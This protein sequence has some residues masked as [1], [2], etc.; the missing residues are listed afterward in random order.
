[1]KSLRLFD[2]RVGFSLGALSVLLGMMAPAAIPM[3]ASA[4]QIT[5]RSI[6]M[7]NTSVSGS[8]GTNVSYNL[9]FTP[10]QAGVNSD[11]VVLWFCSD[12][13]LAGASCAAPSGMSL[14]SASL[15]N[16]PGTEAIYNTSYTGAGANYLVFGTASLTGGSSYSITV[17]GVTNPSTAGTFY[18]RI[19]T[20]PSTD[21]TDVKKAGGDTG[22]T[23]TA[24]GSYVT[25]MTDNGSVALAATN[26]IGVSAS[27]LESLTF[28]TFGD[29]GNATVSSGQYTVGTN[30]SSGYLTGLAN[31][32]HGPNGDCTD[33][34][35]ANNGTSI[36]LGQQ[37]ATGVLA[38]S[39]ST[40]SYGYGWTGLSTNA[41]GGA[42]VYM[43]NN[44]P[45]DGLVLN[46]GSTCG[47]PS[48][49]SG[50]QGL[51][52]AFPSAGTAAYGVTFGA[53]ASHGAFAAPTSTATGAI[54]INSN[55]KGQY[56][57]VNS[58]P[59][60]APTSSGQNAAE[61]GLV[62]DVD[63]TYGG[64]VYGT[65]GSPAT[66]QDVPFGLAAGISPS[67]PAGRYSNN[68]SLIAVGTF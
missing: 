68:L 53:G 15:T 6:S 66:N 29:P 42:I 28:C 58:H 31:A 64:F 34:G 4:A 22:N 27:V 38:L 62:Q 59:T 11:Y 30:D 9:T 33:T 55:Y 37:A 51:G 17:A 44:S 16:R 35:N 19:E 40:P 36:V 32:S 60:T 54:D 43:K 48:V 52:A 50:S 2:R 61:N 47:I 1:M 23:G 8:G 21:T 26:Q 13:P 56:A 10:A 20:F 18:A 14:S 24:N 3:L 7:S 67:T 41:S 5:A 49:N 25:G 45:C 65:E 46:N 63:S 39:T 12:S 57:L